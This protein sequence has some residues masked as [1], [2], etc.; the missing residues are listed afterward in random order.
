MRQ[1][2]GVASW[3]RPAEFLLPENEFKAP[4]VGRGQLQYLRGPTFGSTS[5]QR[6]PFMFP[7]VWRYLENLTSLRD[8]MRQVGRYDINSAKLDQRARSILLGAKG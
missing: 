8:A 6:A 4:P 5:R 7:V 1:I 3:V 2:T